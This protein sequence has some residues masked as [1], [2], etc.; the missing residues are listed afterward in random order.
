MI[1][2]YLSVYSLLIVV[3]L[4]QTILHVLN[5]LNPQYLAFQPC[6]GNWE[7]VKVWILGIWSVTLNDCFTWSS[8][9]LSSWPRRTPRECINF[10]KSSG[11]IFIGR[12]AVSRVCC[13]LNEKYDYKN[14]TSLPSSSTYS[15]SDCST[16]TMKTA[17][18][19]D[20]ASFIFVS[21]N[22]QFFQLKIRRKPFDHIYRQKSD[23]ITLPKGVKIYHLHETILV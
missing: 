6:D 1:T 9:R 4:R 13:R 5:P 15:V 8:S 23:D 21:P 11:V 17:W 22:K 19:R 2:I 20:D 18:E 3:L 14:V 7:W 10:W 16:I 12:T